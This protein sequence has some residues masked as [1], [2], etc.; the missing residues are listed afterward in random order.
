M[1]GVT[2]GACP[3]LCVCATGGRQ[4]CRIRSRDQTLTP[5]QLLYD[6]SLAQAIQDQR[7]AAPPRTILKASRTSAFRNSL[8]GVFGAAAEMEEAAPPGFRF[9]AASTAKGVPTA[10][11]GRNLIMDRY[12][13]TN[14]THRKSRTKQVNK[15]AKRRQ[16][17]PK[18]L[19]PAGC[20]SSQI[21]ENNA[22]QIINPK[23]QQLMVPME[24]L[25]VAPP[26]N[27]QN[28]AAAEMPAKQT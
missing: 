12:T 4:V 23:I 1:L 25:A 9:G 2:L 27:I 10:A 6:Y 17:T 8:G 13:Q 11:T 28:S 3:Q 14:Q 7:D 22:I 24:I 26:Q 5:D 16:E 20:E 15:K 19:F 18:K 21:E